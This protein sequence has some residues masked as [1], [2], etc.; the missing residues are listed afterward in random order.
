VSD[1]DG[2]ASAR[3]AKEVGGSAFA[4]AL[5]VCDAEACRAAARETAERAGSLAVWVNNAAV[6]SP[7]YVWDHAPAERRAAFEVNAL[8]TIN[9]TL[10]ALE[11][12]RLA[13]SGTW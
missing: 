4:S 13:A 5:D 1:V 3:T 6:F 12:M 10:A 11:L 7:G 2:D 9:G 8:G